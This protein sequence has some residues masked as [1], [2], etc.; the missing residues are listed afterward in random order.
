MKHRYLDMSA[1]KQAACDRTKMPSGLV[2]LRKSMPVTIE[3]IDGDRRKLFTISTEAV[4]RDNDT[5]KLAGWDLKAYLRNPVVL[6]GHR[7]YD[8]PVGRSVEIGTEGGALKAV[9]EFVPADMPIVGEM[10]EMVYRMVDKGFL[11]ACSVGFRP[12]EYE[13][14]KERDDDDSWMT[15]LDFLKQE[16]L[17]WSVCTIP[18]N[19]E[20]IVNPDDEERAATVAAMK[21]A[22]EDAAAAAAAAAAHAAA[23]AAQ[24]ESVRAERLA[25]RREL[26][27]ACF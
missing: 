23:N 21:T 3:S 7:S 22:A 26:R 2:C 19:P 24:L 10:A 9:V 13:K 5:I 8:P 25:R 4:D 27:A 15:P 1:F 18:S 16:L 17:E 6:W 12:L 11:S 20:A 14:A